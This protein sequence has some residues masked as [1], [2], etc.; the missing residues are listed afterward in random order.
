MK[1]QS[2]EWI[3]K[4]DAFFSLPKDHPL[5]LQTYSKEPLKLYAVWHKGKKVGG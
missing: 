2:D 1:I 3:M 4:Q 5:V